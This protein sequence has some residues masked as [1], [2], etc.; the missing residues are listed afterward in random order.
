MFNLNKN[1][2]GQ[3]KIAQNAVVTTE[4]MLIENNE[5]LGLEPNEED[6][7]Y[8]KLLESDREN[9]VGDKNYEK[10]LADVRVEASEDRS[11][12]E[13]VLNNTKDTMNKLRDEDTNVPLMD[14]AK[15]NVVE[16]EKAYQKAIDASDSDTSFWDKYVG[17]QLDKDQITK[18]TNNVQSSQLVS[19][20][21][22]REDFNKENPSTG[23]KVPVAV[24]E[25][26]KD[27]DAMLYFIYRTAEE[28][29]REL[30]DKEK[31]IITDINSGKIRILSQ[32]KPEQNLSEEEW[33]ELMR[34]EQM[35]M[36][37]DDEE[38]QER[39][40]GEIAEANL[41]DTLH[42]QQMEDGLEF[43]DQFAQKND[44][45]ETQ[46]EANALR[47][48]TEEEEIL[49]GGIDPLTGEYGRHADTPS[50]D[51]PWWSDK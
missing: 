47:Q 46:E 16:R 19:N 15:K 32:F 18:I 1:S 48:R 25:I 29:S 20:Y 34:E 51:K 49:R 50:L 5:E 36:Q 7:N 3:K 11:I 21:D 30:S 22:T 13:A 6:G 8:N 2:K 37:A 17:Q 14:F 12:L 35:L 43:G 33:D 31:Q 24:D 27:A 42:D 45:W 4:K 39:M 23:K 40:R 9:P 10:L 28:E 38:S 41:P 26:L 44:G